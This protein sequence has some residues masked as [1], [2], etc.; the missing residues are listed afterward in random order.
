VIFALGAEQLAS[1]TPKKVT[2]I[3]RTDFMMATSLCYSPAIV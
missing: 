3:R 2:S 1:M